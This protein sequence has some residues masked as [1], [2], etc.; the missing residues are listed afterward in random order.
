MSIMTINNKYLTIFI[1]LFI[2]S[3]CSA[4]NDF[5]SVLDSI[6]PKKPEVDIYLLDSELSPAP[7]PELLPEPVEAETCIAQELDELKKTGPWTAKEQKSEPIGPKYNFPIVR[8][9]QVDMYLNLFQGKQRKYFSKWLARSTKYQPLMESELKKAGLPTDLVYLA[10]IESGFNQRA[11]S[12]ARAVG[13]WQFMKGTA[14]G[15]NLRIDRYV[16]ERRNALKS[17]KAAVAFLSDLHKQFG[18]W[19][20][21]VAAYNAGPGKIRKGLKRY[22]TDSFWTLAQKRYL[23]LETKRYVPKL[24]AAIIIAKDPEKYG[25]TNI[26]YQSPMKYDTIEV[27]PGLSLDALALISGGT[28]KELRLLNQELKTK[29]T[30][31]NQRKYLAHI[32]VGSLAKA[33]SG[34]SRLHSVVRTGYKTHI[35]RKGETLTQICRKYNVNKTTI[36]KVNSLRSGKI[37][38]GQRLRIPYSIVDY[39]LLPENGTPLAHSKDSLRLHK[40]KKGETIS[41]IARQYSVPADMIVAWNG[42]KSVHQI[43]AGQQLALYILSDDNNTSAIPLI[44][45]GKKSQKISKHREPSNVIVLSK[46]KKTAPL[47]RQK[48]DAFSW[49]HVKPGDTLWTISRRFNTS[50]KMIKRW[51]NLKSNLIH[52]GSK[53]RLKNV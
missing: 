4:Q 20:L 28:K 53:L 29:R 39:T 36:L 33:S 7:P 19:H 9:K 45:N 14:R 32:P 30:P 6:T 48:Q 18:D 5:F 21:A 26:Q 43:R 42:L 16:D 1:L 44:Q 25:F 47:S 52:P 13:L 11:Y 2:F 27:G 37:Q 15:Y 34:L 51:N 17:T 10:M 38:N 8:N 24:I 23:R 41:K 46:N 40:I 31:L 49:Y 12:R 50:P 35:K 3:G 22:K